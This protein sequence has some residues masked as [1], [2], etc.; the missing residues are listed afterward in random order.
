MGGEAAADDLGA[1]TD[2]RLARRRAW[3]RWVGVLLYLPFVIVLAPLADLLYWISARAVP[4]LTLATLTTNPS[5]FGGGLYAPITGTAFLMGVSA[6]L[7]T[8]LGVLA[9]MYTAEF[10]SPRVASVARLGAHLLAGVP[11]IVIGYF[12]YFALV[13][14]LGWGYSLLAGAVTLAFFMVPYIY[15]T[16]D[17]A[18][19][20]VPSSQREAARGAGATGAQYLRRVAWPIAFPRVL[21]GIFV[22]LAIGVGE[23]APLLFTAGWNNVP[24]A[25]LGSPTS[26]LTGVIWLFFDYPSSFGTDQTLAFQA[27]FLLIV[28]VIGLNIVIQLI[29]ERARHRLQGLYR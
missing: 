3:D 2:R 12:G 26:Y 25:A 9:G 10:A 11:A 1:G 20:S 22:A 15:R 7:A 27:A 5:G 24:A 18:F 13:L 21:T 29:A 17:L 19:G 6:G 8:V 16:A 14:Y 23:T 4:T 28:V